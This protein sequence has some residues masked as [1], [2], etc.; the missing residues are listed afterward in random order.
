MIMGLVS[1]VKWPFETSLKD[2]CSPLNLRVHNF[3][4]EIFYSRVWIVAT[5]DA[6]YKLF[7]FIW[8]IIERGFTSRR[9]DE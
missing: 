3:P 8:R 5:M 2:I 4:I 1:C 7:A 9:V 6:T